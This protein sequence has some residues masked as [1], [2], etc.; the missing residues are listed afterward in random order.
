MKC[1]L[2]DDVLCG[3]IVKEFVESLRWILGLEFFWMFED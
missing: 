3:I 1:N 2:V